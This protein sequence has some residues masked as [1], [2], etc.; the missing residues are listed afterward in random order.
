MKR[1][2]KL[3]RLTRQLYQR[4]AAEVARINHSRAE[5]GQ[6][7]AATEHYLDTADA[8][9][10]FLMQLSLVRAARLRRELRQSD[11]QLASSL[12]DAVAA[13]TSFRGADLRLGDER[14][15]ADRDAAI[16]ALAD[17][18]DNLR[19]AGEASLEQGPGA[20][21]ARAGDRASGPDPAQERHHEAPARKLSR[22]PPGSR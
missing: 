3:V 16:E 18:I 4:Q 13:L 10:D 14:A 15:R 22:S 20:S 5:L 9:L 6:L 2:R 21:P 12:D 1:L 7:A 19:C 17:T 8:P 11:A